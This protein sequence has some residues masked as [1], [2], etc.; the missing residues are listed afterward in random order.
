MFVER[1]VAAMEIKNKAV[2]TKTYFFTFLKWLFCATVLGLFCGI[3][4]ILFHDLI[5]FANTLRKS[6]QW[7]LYFLPV[8]GIVIALIY[9]TG[10]MEN[11]GG[12]NDIFRSI[13]NGDK[14]PLRLAPF[15]FIGTVLTHLFGGSSGREGAALQMGGSI[16]AFCGKLLKMNDKEMTV[17]KMCGMSAVFSAMFGTPLTAALFSIEVISVGVFQYSA[18]VPCMLSSFSAFFVASHLG[19]EPFAFPLLGQPDKFDPLLF[20][21]V[22]ALSVACAVV[23][24]LVC[25]SF[26][27][28]HKVYKK[29]FKNSVLRAFFGGLIVVALMFTVGT[30]EYCGAGTPII[31]AALCGTAYPFAFLLKLLFTSLTLGAGFR[32]G[33]II[34]T[35]FIGAT[36]GCTVGSFFGLDPAF[37][38]AISLICVF[39]G[40]VNCP[41]SSIILSVEM[42]GSDALLYFALACAVG[43]MLSGKY[44]LYSGQ[45]FMFSK[46]EPSYSGSETPQPM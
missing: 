5:D 6:H 38:A 46:L 18:I 34:P 33:E 29:L 36:F 4:G 30:D 9:K 12:T 14:V 39:C 45:E 3:L 19:L 32:G 16:G 1:H 37:S 25:T 35:L 17:V 26:R 28:F 21:K 10:N 40:V 27:F 13:R 11:H 41:V 44:S 20:G 24:I 42:F 7:M 22:I 43:Y 8:G 2:W 23:S 15:V 31:A